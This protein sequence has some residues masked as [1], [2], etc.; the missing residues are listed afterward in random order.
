MS[1]LRWFSRMTVLCALGFAALTAGCT[2]PKPA[3]EVP[4]PKPRNAADIANAIVGAK[5]S[6][7]VYMDRVRGHAIAARVVALEEVKSTFEGTGIDPMRDL[8]QAIL[9]STG[10]HRDDQAVV[11]AQHSVDETKLRAALDGMIARSEPKGEWLD[12]GVPAAKVTVRGHTRVV[13]L[14]EP[15]FIAVVPE[16]LARQTVRLKGTGG[17]PENKGKQAT[18]TEVKDPAVTLRAPHA[19]EVPPTVQSARIEVTLTPDGGADVMTVGQSKDEAQAIADAQALTEEV[20]RATS[21]RIAIV[22]VRLFKP[23][24]FRAEGSSVRSDL[25]LTPDEIDMLF[26]LI[27]R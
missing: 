4:R 21:I 22:R 14:V 10:I 2:H 7:M 17:F 18:I 19:P 24:P 12:V 20:E 11:V 6:T 1:A 8:Q 27:P 26:R 5:V 25:H 3:V 16:A 13:A 23:V 15:G 9:A